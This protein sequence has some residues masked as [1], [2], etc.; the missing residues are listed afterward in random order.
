[1]LQT[2]IAS[3]KGRRILDAYLASLRELAKSC[4]FGDLE[5][6]MIRDQIVKKYSFHT[7]AQM[8]LQQED[9]DLAKNVK[10]A[11]RDLK[12]IQSPLTTCTPLVDRNA[13]NNCKKVGDPQGVYRSKPKTTVESATVIE[14]SNMKR[15]V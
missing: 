4:E 6:E 9:L 5:E 2:P 8:L 15:I 7:L 1:M 13:C 12:R 14:K 3:T 10:I 11:C